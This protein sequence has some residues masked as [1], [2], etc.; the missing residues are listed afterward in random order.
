MLAEP[1]MFKNCLKLGEVT[2]A[3]LCMMGELV[4]PNVNSF[5]KDESSGNSPTWTQGSNEVAGKSVAPTPTE[6][7]AGSGLGAWIGV[8]PER[9][10]GFEVEI[11]E[12]SEKSTKKIT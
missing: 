1:S 7:Q 6:T 8:V 9:K 2:P 10:Y 3:D 11:K 12:N 4:A 5:K